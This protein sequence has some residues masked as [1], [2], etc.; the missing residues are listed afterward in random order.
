MN[1][2]RSVMF[3]GWLAHHQH[4]K[5]RAPG[6]LLRC[7]EFLALVHLRDTNL[8]PRALEAMDKIG[9]LLVKLDILHTYGIHLQHTHS[10]KPSGTL[11]L[12]ACH[13]LANRMYGISVGAKCTRFGAK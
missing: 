7:I 12:L 1:I 6:L 11:L 2:K 3:N 13:L 4:K 8:F 5:Y 10:L 9:A